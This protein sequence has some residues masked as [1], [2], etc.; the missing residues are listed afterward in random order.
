MLTVCPVAVLKKKP[1][2]ESDTTNTCPPWAYS[3]SRSKNTPVALDRAT[4]ASASA[5]RRLKTESVT[6]AGEFST[7]DGR[8]WIV[9]EAKPWSI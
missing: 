3:T 6:A 4:G 7:A 2:G 9:T 1:A 8:T 5:V